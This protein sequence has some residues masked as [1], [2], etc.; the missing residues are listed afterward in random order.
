[1]GDEPLP[2]IESKLR[3]L[4][5]FS[6]WRLQPDVQVGIVHVASNQNLDRDVALVSRMTTAPRKLLVLSHEPAMTRG[7][8]YQDEEVSTVAYPIGVNPSRARSKT[9]AGTLPI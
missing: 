2:E 6:A 3:S 4:D 1:V 5:I 9:L 7:L 8:E